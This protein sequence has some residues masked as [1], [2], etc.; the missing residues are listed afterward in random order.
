VHLCE[1]MN[2][3]K[4]FAIKAVDKTKLRKRRL[5]LNDDQLRQEV[6]SSFREWATEIRPCRFDQ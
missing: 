2:T 1:D 4:R 3:G 6:R 5:G